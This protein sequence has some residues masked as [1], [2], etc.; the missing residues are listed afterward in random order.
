[1]LQWLI[2]KN[3]MSSDDK[4]TCYLDSTLCEITEFYSECCTQFSDKNSVKSYVS[5]KDNELV[6]RKIFSSFNEVYN[7]L[8]SRNFSS[9]LQLSKQNVLDFG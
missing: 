5:L 4:N 3:G 6:S 9:F 7:K 8:I 1:M 2:G